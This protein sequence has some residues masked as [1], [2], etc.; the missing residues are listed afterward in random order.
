MAF[1]FN[2]FNGGSDRV[3]R[4]G[5]DTH[6]YAFTH[7]KEF[8]GKTIYVNGWFFTKST[9]AGKET[10][11]PVVIGDGINI[12]F[13]S[14]SADRFKKLAADPEAVK[15]VLNGELAVVNIHVIPAKEKGMNDTWGF[16]FCNVDDIGK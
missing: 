11:Q 1:N 7:I 8:I 15:A 14:W 3:C 16:D 10:I 12:N 5:I 13:P 2:S 9:M 4:S 6:D